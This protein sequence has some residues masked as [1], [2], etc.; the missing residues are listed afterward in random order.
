MADQPPSTGRLGG[1][2][3]TRIG[4]IAGTVVVVA[5]FASWCAIV[6]LQDDGEP[7]GT[8]GDETPT[9]T[10]GSPT[11]APTDL[12][13][14]P[15]AAATASP[16]P[17]TTTAPSPTVGTATSEPATATTAPTGTATVAPTATTTRPAATATRTPT[18]APTATSTATPTATATPTVTP[19]A[20]PTATPTVA[21]ITN[22]AGTWNSVGTCD[23]PSAP[24]R[25]S[26][27]L[28]QQ[29]AAVS[30]Y[31]NFHLCPGGG[32]VSYTVSGTATSASSIQLS[33]TKAGGIGGLYDSTPNQVTFTVTKFGPPSPNYA[34]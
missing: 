10:V 34:P 12:P 7:S 31:I 22:F 4:L 11:T 33:G 29:G 25:W 26:I 8:D 18:P 9:T 19:T 13:Q 24:F 27:G 17:T 1:S 20:T 30:G 32:Q 2:R 5:L 14:S 16:V 15:T 6:A 28:T 3:L 21:A 23:N